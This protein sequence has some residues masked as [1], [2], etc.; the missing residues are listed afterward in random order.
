MTKSL[1]NPAVERKGEKKGEAKGEAKGIRESIVTI[2]TIKFSDI[3]TT[4]TQ[5]IESETNINVLKDWLVKIISLNDL[6]D[7]EKMIMFRYRNN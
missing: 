1:Y 5:T 6:S 4:I 3:S 7:I 2:L